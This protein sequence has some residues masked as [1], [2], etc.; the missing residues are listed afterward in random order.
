MRNQAE[1]INKAC[2]QADRY[3]IEKSTE[4]TEVIESKLSQ[5]RKLRSI[6]AHYRETTSEPGL[7]YDEMRWL[8]GLIIK[9]MKICVENNDMSYF[10]AKY[11]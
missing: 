11:G 4:S 1:A 10:E 9:M 8:W 2:I 7:F 5:I 6:E 3:G